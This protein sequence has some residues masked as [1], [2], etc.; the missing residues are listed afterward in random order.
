MLAVQE[1]R[2]EITVSMQFTSSRCRV[3]VGQHNHYIIEQNVQQE[4]ASIILQRYTKNV[5]LWI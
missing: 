1:T 2:N 5:Y 4:R 3:S